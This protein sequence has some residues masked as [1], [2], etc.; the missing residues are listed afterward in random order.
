MDKIRVGIFFGGPSREREISFAGGRT[1]YDNLDKSLF[2]PIPIFVDSLAKFI[3]LDWQYIYKGSI[4]DFYP[5][6]DAIPNSPNNFQIYIESLPNL[7]RN[8]HLEII[9]KVG[10]PLN[11][12]A[13]KDTIDVAFLA[14]HGA[15]GEDGS[16][17]GL[18]DFLDIPF[19][20]SGILPSAIGINKSVQK[21][22]MP[23]LDFESKPSISIAQGENDYI[24]FFKEVQ[25]KVGF[26]CVI[27]P[28]H[29]GSSIGVSILKENNFQAFSKLI[30]KAFFKETVIIGDWNSLEPTE[31]IAEIRRITDIRE[32]VG[33]PLVIDQE[34]IYHP[35]ALLQ[36][37]NE[38][39]EKELL[40]EG[41]DGE[42]EVLIEGFI[43]GKEF[44]CIVI[45]DENGKSVALPPTEIMKGQEVYDYRSKYM[46]GLSRKKTP[47]DLPFETIQNIQSKCIAL[48]EA[49][50]FHTYAR[51]DGFYDS[52]GKIYLNDPNTTSGMLPSS[53]FFH[54][55]AE[56]GWNPSQFLNFII[57][58]SVAERLR[59]STMPHKYQNLIQ[60]IDQGLV[61]QK[62]S[63]SVKQR[64]GIV[65]GGYSFE[66]H[67]SVESGRNV[68]EKLASSSKYEAIPIFLAANG[69]DFD[70]YQI[71]IHLL[72]KDNA[73]DIR[74]NILDFKKHKITEKLKQQ[75]A[76]LIEKYRSN[77]TVLAPQKL[78]KHQLKDY[79]DLV[80]IALHGRPGEDG[81]LQKL[82]VNQQIPFNGSMPNS[83]AITI[84]KFETL[85]RLK[86]HGFKVTDQAVFQ[87]EAYLADSEK[88]IKQLNQTLQY[89]YILKPLDDGCSSAVKLIKNDTQLSAYLDTMFR[90]EK[91][92]DPAKAA[93]L[94]LKPKEEFP[95]KSQVLAEA[96]IESNGAKKF[97]EIT[98]GMIT[99]YENGKLNYEMFHPSEALA[100]SEILSLE[101]KFLAGEGQNITPAR[102]ATANIDYDKVANQ[103]RSD[104]KRAATICEV[105]GYCR[106]DAFVR[107]FDENNI[108]TIIIEINS[109]PGMTPATAIFHQSALNNYKPFN[110]IDQILQ[111]GVERNSKTN[112]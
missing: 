71:P 17:Q 108:E 65:L 40:L 1:V 2:E 82:L 84:N 76:S 44:S 27:R 93:I 21:E 53:F 78:D 100:G 29:Q 47:I 88:V 94:D 70:L 83:A 26:P 60:R 81:T 10:K 101:E 96:L 33:L 4:R 43:D 75:S 106:I 7:D 104:L 52:A 46:P 6:V 67:I 91:D 66:R 30:D 38:S 87:R 89:P 61:D 23:L 55:A 28:A 86:E 102:F 112:A 18:L 64:V 50:R 48:F 13:L 51:I 62:N 90:S 105:D 37:L 69:D 45:R 41:L 54:Q 34:S 95:R 99:H 63:A 35:E 110:F 19:T 22:W 3:L 57:R 15:K 20:G 42:I 31:K 103:V 79:V 111:Y 68:Y 32:G 49:F 24:S 58:N 85:Q 98:G 77:Y 72:L 39:S 109:L 80:F 9:K 92:I 5:P 25:E 107:I 14:L 97:L 16:I 74:D 8:Q 73:D 12:E 36:K 59:G 56:V 11:F